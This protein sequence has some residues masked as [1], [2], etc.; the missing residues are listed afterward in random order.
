M[1]KK[2]LIVGISIIGLISIL[3]FIKKDK[4]IKEN[5]TNNYNTELAINTSE[6]G[7]NY[8]IVN[9]VP[10]TGYELNIEKSVC[11]TQTDTSGIENAPK[12][13][14]ITIE[15]KEGKINFLGVSKQ[16]TR[17]YLYFDKK[18]TDTIHV[19]FGDIEVKRTTPDFSK[20]AE[21]DEGIYKFSD[22]VYGGD[23]YYWRGA[24]TNN[25]LIFANKCWRIVRVNGD[26]TTR[27]IYNGSV[28]S[29]STCAG[30]GTNSESVIMG[31]TDSEKYYATSDGKNDNPSYVGW[32]FTLGS[33]RT[34]SGTASNAKIQTEK[35]YNANITGTYA[36][37]VADGKFC[38]DR[39]IRPG[40]SW[41]SQ[42][43][44]TFYYA[45]YDRTGVKGTTSVMPTLECN[46]GDVYN[47]KVGAITA[48][49]IVMAGS[50]YNTRNTSYYLNNGYY[51]WTMTPFSFEYQNSLFYSAK[52]YYVG[53]LGFIE[54]NAANV[55]WTTPGIRP[56]I[57][58]RS[59]IAFSGGNGTQN[60]PYIVQ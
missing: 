2:I 10:T 57:N 54:A 56:V 48:D 23:S 49:E 39:N 7:T 55:S 13:N 53:D 1:K 9:E 38:N 47:L 31:S 33:Q 16:R 40:Y 15:Y 20:I 46:S 26:G 41:T 8:N 45:G 14:N 35:W 58:L 27:L 36:N 6:D 3:P 34:L 60:N 5:I 17:C 37:K 30:N 42:P 4:L 19:S 44:S 43:S 59:D 29:G 18:E 24:V 28:K 21:F 51:Y 50:L 25:H 52:V 22:P 12:D 32:T 11:K